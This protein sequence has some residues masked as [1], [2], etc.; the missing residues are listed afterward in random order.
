MSHWDSYY[1]VALDDIIHRGKKQTNQRTGQGLTAYPGLHFRIELDRGFPVLTT[2]KVPLK[3]FTAEMVWFCSGSDDI[4]WLQ[5]Y[6]KVWNKFL[7]TNGKLAAPY[8]YRW[9][10]SFGRDQLRNAIIALK[11]DPTNR[12]VVV[13]TW[14]ARR[15]GLTN[16]GR[17]KNVPCLPMWNPN[18]I[19]GKLNLAVEVR[20][21]DMILGCPHDVAGF[22][23]LA[24]FL[25]A[26]LDVEP[27]ILSYHISHAHI[28]DAHLDAA[29][30]LVDRIGYGHPDIN[31]MANQSW[32]GM[33]MA[34][35]ESGMDKV[36]SEILQV[37]EPQYKP[38]ESVGK[39][40]LF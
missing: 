20:S 34:G 38:G 18:I 25:A 26:T 3:L 15:D 35:V 2:R 14:D 23:L 9:R 27:G 16:Q 28:Y 12:Q 19:D 36:V 11:K 10:H 22:A 4:T 32:M 33:A 30:T 24:H 40:P 31:F 7:E 6:T 13:A 1:L 5:K 8:G 21:N 17:V 37:L 39:L 29:K